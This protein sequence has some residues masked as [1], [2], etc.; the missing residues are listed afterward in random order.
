MKDEDDAIKKI[1]KDPKLFYNYAKKSSKSPNQIGPFMEEDGTIVSEPYEKAEKLRIQYESVFSKPDE[2]WKIED[3]DD[4]FDVSSNLGQDQEIQEQNQERVQERVQEKVCSDCQKEKV[5]E[6][7]SDLDHPRDSQS[8]VRDSLSQVGD[9]LS[10]VRD[11]RSEASESSQSIPGDDQS[12]PGQQPQC[13][14]A[15]Q[16]QQENSQKLEEIFFDYSD[17]MLAI[18]D[19]PNGASPGPDGVP[20]CLLKKAKVNISRMLMIIF[21][22]SY[23]TGNI[24]DILKLALVSPIHK[25]GSRSNPAQ[26]RPISLTSHIIKVFE[27]MLRK[28]MIGYLEYFEKMDK[29]QHGS[30]S[31][32]SCLSQLLEHHL[33]IL[34]MLERGEN[35]DLVY[36]DFAKAFDK[37]DI[38]H[39][40]HK[41]KSAGITGRLGRWIHSFL[42]GR[43]QH[44]VVN[45]T[46]SKE[47]KVMSG[48][49][50]GTVLGPLLFLIY[51]SDIGDD[52]ESHLKVYVDDTK[53]K[54]GI[55]MEEDVESLQDDL[56][57]MYDWAT[58]NNMEFNG[59]KFQVMRYGENE[60]LKENTIY[61]TDKMNHVIEEFENL[62]DLGVIMNNEANFKDHIDKA[63][64]KARQKMGWVLRTFYSRRTWFMK[65]MFKTLVMPHLDYCSQLWLP[66]DAAGI[67]KLEKVQF[68][69]LKKIPELRD[70]SYWEALTHM[71]MISV[72]RRMERYRLIYCWKI[73]ENLA[74]NCGISEIPNTHETRQGRRLDI[75]KLKG[76]AKI[77]KMKEQC[78]QINGAKMFNCLPTKIRNLTM[79]PKF[80]AHSAPS[81]DDFKMALDLYLETVPDQP[82]IDGLSP[83][84][85]TNSLLHQTKRGHT[86]GLPSS[87]GA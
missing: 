37:C 73:L 14:V 7:P 83:G 71:K 15:Q 11:S 62:K 40:L 29:N 77:Q 74:P 58:E 54:K 79:K 68:D 85:D 16:R 84:V 8:Q 17:V 65:H 66:V 23:E 32:R 20:P 67:L 25:G 72:Q 26:Y 48:V 36:L 3:A 34:D 24:P 45:G 42:K 80:L 33:E 10:Q 41:L 49:P 63:V 12:E 21:K 76:T 64:R 19:I 1:S 31:K 5:H 52:I 28:T 60:T 46:K 38:D 61:F 44:V 56:N 4:F 35:V 6:C 39:L 13:T 82:R 2:K 70:K 55:K 75:P 27:R 86:G 81:V 47:T 69:F 57:K 22:S 53:A 43:K 78:F 87:R 51:L 50:Q 30:R 9:S 59:T 18:E